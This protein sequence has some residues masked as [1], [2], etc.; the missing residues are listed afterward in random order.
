[1]KTIRLTPARHEKPFCDDYDDPEEVLR[2]ERAVRMYRAYAEPFE[3]VPIDGRIDGAYRV[4][5]SSGSA[6]HVDLVDRSGTHDACS[7]A[8]FLTNELGTCKHLEA[9][10]RAV[11]RVA[12]LARAFE[13]LPER[14]GSP[15]LTVRGDGGMTLSALGR[16]SDRRLAS[17]GL[18][19]V[20]RFGAGEVQPSATLADGARLSPGWHGDL[21]VV[22]AAPLAAQQLRRKLALEVRR[23][24]IAHALARGTLSLD[25]LSEPLFPYQR[26]GAAHL[27]KA[28]RALLADDMGLGKTAQAIAA[29]ELLRARGEAA[30]ILIVTLA[31]LKHQWARE[32]ERFAGVHAVVVGG[33]PVAR[34]HALQSDAPYK[35]LNYELTWREL[36]NLK[37]LDADVV[38]YDEAQRAKNFRTKTA[39]TIQHIPSRFVFLLTGTPVENRLDD[40]YALTQ[41]AD[42]GVFG[43]LWK[44]NMEFHQQSDTG[45]VVSYK[46]LAKLRER[47]EPFV[48]RRRKEDVLTQLP[49]LTEQTRYTPL[50]AAQ[51]ELEQ[52][53]RQ[54]AAQ[55]M[56]Q[57]SRRA[58]TKRE[59]D[60]LM[61]LM[62]KARQ[63]CN[64]AELCDPKRHGS[65]KLDE[66]AALISEIVAQGTS[67]VLVFSEWVDMLKLAGQR[68]DAAG[69]GHAMLHGGVPTDKRPALL[70]R[71]RESDDVRVLLSTEAGGV[72]LNLQVASYVIHLDL[73][74]NPAR[75][76]QRT[77]RA[78]RMGQTRGV[79][80][81]YLC[82][83]EGIERAIEKT[84][85]GKRAVRSAALDTDSVVDTLESPT[86]TLFLGELREAL[87]TCDGSGVQSDIDTDDT[88]EAASAGTRRLAESAIPPALPADAGQTASA[89]ATVKSVK[90]A[91]HSIEALPTDREREPAAPVVPPSRCGDDYARSRLALAR[92]VLEA[93]FP[94]DAVK[95]AYEALAAAIS[96]LLAEPPVEHSS[97]VAAIFRELL[98]R[99]LLPA[100]AHGSLARLHDLTSLDAHGVE[101]DASLAHAAV[102]EAAEWIAR[103]AAA[104]SSFSTMSRPTPGARL[105]RASLDAQRR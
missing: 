39:R 90:L 79:S 104:Q 95:A 51:R 31:S 35:I 1:M 56:A 73:P 57:A 78:H 8:D 64:A 42:P 37:T 69:I 2:F 5:G 14:P 105:D 77:S 46:N 61:M 103:V 63:A 71:F 6:Y 21:R 27:L 89:L 50:T 18:E 28:G 26:E 58:L 94:G 15:V 75:L 12:R 33:N 38:V 68:L 30:R 55:L 16:L 91:V 53:Y 97:L 44:F 19:R 52:D 76:E 85:A 11:A 102:L 41:I 10:R 65:P 67:K 13:A 32:I 82:A 4:T 80:A 99:G 98:P 40:L 34:R 36:M 70:D 100:G 93:G 101:V 96:G 43:P 7:C 23:K 54:K 60:V 88:L 92:V 86:F 84:L 66:F 9:V 45:K 25:V 72:G 59:Q 83:E 48:L 47:M 62:L 22:Y 20:D 81:I 87:E 17:L 29:C 49:S 3:I 24:S 74:W